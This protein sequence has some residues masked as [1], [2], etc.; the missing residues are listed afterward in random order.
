MDWQQSTWVQLVAL[1][2]GVGPQY[3][4]TIFTHLRQGRPLSIKR[5]FLYTILIG[6]TMTAVM[7]LLLRYLCGER[8]R[9][10]NLQPGRWWLDILVGV[11]LAVLTLGVKALTD[12]PI[13]KAFPRKE[14][15]GLG[16]VVDEMVSNP[17]L[18]ALIIGPML[19]FGAGVFEELTRVFMLT[20]LWNLGSSV[21]WRWSAVLLSALLFGLIHLYQGPAGVVSTG[22]FGLILAVYYALF[23][24]VV[25]MMVGHYLNDAIQF[26]A[27]YI[28]EKRRRRSGQAEGGSVG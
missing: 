4:S 9:D 8:I 26:T 2:V 22:I 21:A 14:A 10:L 15:S 25:P 28:V 27:V 7:L 11:G 23:G 20:R 13:N 24:R 16:T 6:G 5:L 18:F 3:I 19:V 1:L 17:L 12:K